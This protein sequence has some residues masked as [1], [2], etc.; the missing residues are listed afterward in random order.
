MA[1]RR[2]FS[3]RPLRLPRLRPYVPTPDAPAVYW[4][5]GERDDI[6]HEVVSRVAGKHDR[7]PRS[8][9][10]MLNDAA[11]HEV[12]RL[13]SQRDEETRESLGFW[14]GISRGIARMSDADKQ[15]ILSTIAER[16]ARDVAGNFDPRVFE[17]ATAAG[18]KLLSA[19][20]QPSRVPRDLT[21]G[22]SAVD[23]LLT[24]EGDVSHLRRLQAHGTLVYVPTHSSNLDS[25]VLA[26]ALERKGLAP[27]VYGAG[28]NLFTNPIIAFGMHNLGAYRVDRRVRAHLY[29]DVLKAYASVMVERGYHSLFFPGGTRSRSGLI[30]QRLKLG[31][32]GSAVEAFSRNQVQGIDRRVYIVPT[33]INYALVLEAET[34]VEDWLKEE[35]QARFIITDD[36][37]SRIERWYDFFRRLRDQRAACVIRFGAPLDPFGNPVDEEGRSLS[38]NGRVIDP[39]SYVLRQGEPTLDA[40]RDQAYTRELGDVLS[41]RFLSDTVLMTTNVVAHALFRHFVRETP[42]VDLFSRLRLRGDITIERALLQRE[43]EQVRAGLV[44]LEQRGV[45]RVSQ[46]VRTS[47]AEALIT[48]ALRVWLGYHKRIAAREVGQYVS[49]EDPTLL[50]YYQNRVVPFATQLAADTDSATQRAAL[51]ISRLGASR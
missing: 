23:E 8:V 2:R 42:S 18:P 29:K 11:L 40:A 41:A 30:E 10:L 12:R 14:K 4:F 6:I 50:I 44:Q 36:E 46:M 25:I 26:Q 51:E 43:V 16:M 5:N 17:M 15:R 39:G 20:M 3:E 45:V 47:D 32:L 19:I 37:F 1:L 48:R 33:T 22:S 35:G 24:V 38:P 49:A 9:E 27:V 28:K 13:T 21:S 7:D 31:L 34:L